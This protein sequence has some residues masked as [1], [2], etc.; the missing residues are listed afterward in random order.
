MAAAATIDDAIREAVA[1]A[2]GDALAPLEA[3]L[4]EPVPAT[5]TVRQAATVIGVSERTVYQLVEDRRLPTVPH[6]GKKVVIPRVA[7][8]QFVHA[9]MRGRVAVAS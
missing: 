3:R 9:G 7:V 8:E 6:L 1:A 5:Y 2:L 4:A